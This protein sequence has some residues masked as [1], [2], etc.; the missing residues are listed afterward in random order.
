MASEMPISIIVA[1]TP[2]G[3]IGKDG[4]LPWNLPQDMCPPV[5]LPASPLYSRSLVSIES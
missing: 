3:G 5:Y 2:K 4:S 1:T